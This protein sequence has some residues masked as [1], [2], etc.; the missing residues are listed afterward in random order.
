MS[1]LLV[2]PSCH[3]KELE[4]CSVDFNKMPKRIVHEYA[5]LVLAQCTVILL[6]QAISMYR[7]PKL[8]RGSV[9]RALGNGKCT[10]ILDVRDCFAQPVVR[11][12]LPEVV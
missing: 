4:S 8:R 1:K 5:F 7:D 12:Q 2:Q 9:C 3:H 11:D 6:R 10:S